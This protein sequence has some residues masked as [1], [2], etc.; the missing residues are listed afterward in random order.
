MHSNPTIALSLISLPSMNIDCVGEMI[1]YETPFN[2]L[3]SV[4]TAILEI[5]LQ[6]LIGRK[7]ITA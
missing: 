6:R 5:I 7:S 4:S 2:R 3:G 1:R